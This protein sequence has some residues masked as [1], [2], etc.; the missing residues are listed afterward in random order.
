MGTQEHGRRGLHTAGPN[1]IHVCDGTG[2]GI[3]TLSWSTSGTTDVD[4]R[5]GA[6]NGSLFSST[7]PTGSGTTGKWVTNGTVFYLQNA[8]YGDR[9]SAANTLATVPVNITTGGCAV[10]CAKRGAGKPGCRIQRGHAVFAY[11][12]QNA[13]SVSFAVW[14]MSNGQNDLVWY[15]GQNL[16]GGTWKATVNFANHPESGQ[17]AAHVYMNNS[18]TDNY[19]GGN[20]T[21]NTLAYPT[22]VTDADGFSS[23]AQYNY[24]MGV[25]TRSQ[26]PKGMVFSTTYDAA[27]R[28]ER[29][30]NETSG[31]YTRFV[32]GGGN[33]YVQ[34]FSLVRAGAGSY[35][36]R[37]LD[38]MGRVR[39]TAAEHP[40][41]ASGYRGQFI[42]YDVMG[43]AVEQTNATEI[44][45]G[46]TPAGDDAAGW[47]WSR[48]SF[49]WKGRPT[50]T[51][52][53]DGTT[54]EASY[55]G[56]G[57]AGGAVVTLRDEV[58]RRQRVTADVLGRAIKPEDLNADG[59][60]YRTAT[61]TYN[62]L[63]QVSRVFVQ[64][65]TSGA[66]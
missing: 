53:V 40:G 2:Y 37:M 39:A 35:S 6:P 45:S 61:T 65:G 63:D 16:G 9:T 38:G 17:F 41:S 43:H 27:G 18:S 47:V 49:D 36:I 57:C 51:T 54:K 20:N 14:G 59:S 4:V 25:A 19:A 31:A 32:Y 50:I 15:P 8:S 7:G 42:K 10:S 34:S 66:G 33:D 13:A 24:D 21:R 12:V 5:V 29:V 60:V 64:A 26:N 52:N 62:A 30:T 55:G 22:Q 44:N 58:G 23:T 28:V 11:G 56:C 46:W 3:T 1:P 48:Q